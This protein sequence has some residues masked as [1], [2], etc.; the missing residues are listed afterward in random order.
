MKSEEEI[1]Q[2]FHQKLGI[3][4]G[5]KPHRQPNLTEHIRMLDWVLSNSPYCRDIEEIVKDYSMEEW[6]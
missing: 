3:W 5:S 6:L 1:R 4:C 2:N